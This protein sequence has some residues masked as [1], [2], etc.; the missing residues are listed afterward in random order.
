MI[1][2]RV[3]I[4][5]IAIL[6]AVTDPS[7]EWTV[8]AFGSAPP[9]LPDTLVVSGRDSCMW[10]RVDRHPARKSRNCGKCCDRHAGR[11]SSRAIRP[12]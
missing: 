9:T 8:A 6:V 1:A 2:T 7:E 4:V 10:L 12:A 5:G 3:R 11:R